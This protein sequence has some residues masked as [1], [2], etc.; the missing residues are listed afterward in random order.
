[1]NL[2]PNYYHAFLGNGLDAVLIGYTG[3][4][5]KDKVGVDRCNWYKSDRYYPEEKLV[6]VAGRWPLGKELEHVEGSGWY[7]LAPL[8]RT[9]YQVWLDGNLQSV[10]ASDQHFVPQEGTLYSAVD[11]GAA[12]VNV[13]TFLHPRRS[14]LIERF[15]FDRQEQGLT[16]LRAGRRE[17]GENIAQGFAGLA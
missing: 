13:I 11:Y 16:K 2:P 12:R 10:Q 14:L 4:M 6:Q 8:G 9:W 7:E 15:E 3:S 5:V 1:M 17:N